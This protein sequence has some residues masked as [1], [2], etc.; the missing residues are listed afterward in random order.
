M[1]KTHNEES[2]T[3]LAPKIGSTNETC[4]VINKSDGAEGEISFLN[5]VTIASENDEEINIPLVRKILR[6]YKQISIIRFK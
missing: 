3:A 6:S 5:A 2:L 1:V 4:V